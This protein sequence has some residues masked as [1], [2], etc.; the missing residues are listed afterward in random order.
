M[1][2]DFDLDDG[3]IMCSP[4]NLFEASPLDDSLLNFPDYYL[5]NLSPENSKTQV[6]DISSE[7]LDQNSKTLSTLSCSSREVSHEHPERWAEVELTIDGI[8]D[9]VPEKK[10]YSPK[11]VKSEE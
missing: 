8:L 6:N 1:N 2:L 11:G 7:K 9:K 10:R 4:P 5:S 3:P